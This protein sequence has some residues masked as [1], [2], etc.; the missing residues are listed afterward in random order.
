MLYDALF[1]IGLAFLLT[2][3]FMVD[4]L[5]GLAMTGLSFM[6]LAVAMADSKEEKTNIETKED[7]P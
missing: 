6:A 5:F 7:K 1:A 2:A 3:F 4:L